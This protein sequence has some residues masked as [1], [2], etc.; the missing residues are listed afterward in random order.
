LLG[1]AAKIDLQDGLLS[2]DASTTWVDALAMEESL[3]LADRGAGDVDALR[4]DGLADYRGHFLDVDQAEPWAAAARVRLR[5]R[6]NRASAARGRELE[7]GGDVAGAATHYARAIDID[8]VFEACYQGLMRCHLARG[9]RSEGI[10]TY[11]RLRLTLR[12]RLALQPGAESDE[13][14]HQL[15]SAG[16]APGALAGNVLPLRR[17]VT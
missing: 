14:L 6:F 7:A 8:D 15:K 12:T 5:S 10:A 16:T 17:N 2:L 9:W 13:L 11:E 3:D 4:R 1:D